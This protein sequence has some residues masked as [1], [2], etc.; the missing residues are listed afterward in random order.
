MQPEPDH[1]VPLRLHALLPRSR[2]NGPGER[3]VV[4]FQGCALAC[5][6]CFNPGT[7]DF[8]AGRVETVGDVL[9]RLAPGRPLDGLTVSGGE[10]FAQPAALR[11]LLAAFRRR[12]GL[13]TLVFSG[14]SL[15][16]IERM[17]SGPAI[18][19]DIDLLVAGRF[20]IKRRQH[21]RPLLGSANQ[22]LH[23]LSGRIVAGE[24][25]QV[26]EA[27]LVIDPQGRIVVTGISPPAA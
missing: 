23:H 11:A 7:H 14:Y 24:L 18:L 20:A 4:W 17:E 3:A 19:A 26:A 13:T 2:A 27:E 12:T 8:G 21:G 9:D 6:G 1:S 25:R 10:P 5:P 15:R 22:R 16:E